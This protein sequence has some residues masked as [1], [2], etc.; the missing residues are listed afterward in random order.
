MTSPLPAIEVFDELGSTNAE[1]M[2]RGRL[3]APHGTAVRACVQTAG[4]GQRAHGWTSPAGGLYLSVL[5][6]PQV[7]AHFLPG[8]PVACALGILDALRGTGCASAQLKWPNDVVVGV[9][10]LAGI[11]TEMAQVGLGGTAAEGASFA[12]CGVGVNMTAPQVEP[13]AGGAAA[14][15]PTG[16]AEELAAAGA[17]TDELPSLD[18]LAGAVRAGILSSV[19]AWEDAVQAAPEDVSPLTPLLDS[20]N[21]HLAYVGKR[22][23]AFAIDGN[24]LDAGTF[25]GVDGFGRAK[26]EHADKT[27]ALYDAATVSLRL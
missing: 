3:G 2:E 22:V 8:L 25:A 5:V 19:A 17:T 14:L 7:P 20:Y 4:R 21:A 26:I 1:V 13:R 27:H 6:R 9:R 16:L 10:K 11:L 15:A 12:V 18:E 24:T 23:T